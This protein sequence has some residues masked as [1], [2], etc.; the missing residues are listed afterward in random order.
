MFSKK[1]TEHTLTKK[2]LKHKLL[3]FNLDDSYNKIGC[4]GYSSEW[5]GVTVVRITLQQ[6]E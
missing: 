4:H 2:V 1:V 3:M 6:P 5:M